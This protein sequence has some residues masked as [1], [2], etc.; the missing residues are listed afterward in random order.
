MEGPATPLPLPTPFPMI[1]ERETFPALEAPIKSIV[2]PGVR[3]SSRGRIGSAFVVK[4]SPVAVTIPDPPPPPP[5][6]A[7]ASTVD[8]PPRGG[9][10][11]LSRLLKEPPNIFPSYASSYTISDIPP[12]RP[13]SDSTTMGP[14][15]L[16]LFSLPARPSPSLR[17]PTGRPK[18]R[19]F[20]ARRYRGPRRGSREERCVFF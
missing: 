12:P 3:T 4:S 9:A 14:L 13:P 7:V 1:S 16:I 6:S 18:W 19:V 15:F 2:A 5:P 17:M 11:R 10:K 8:P 20:P